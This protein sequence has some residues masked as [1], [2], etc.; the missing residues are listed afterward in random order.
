MCTFVYSIASGTVIGYCHTAFYTL[1]AALCSY[2]LCTCDLTLVQIDGR[3]AFTLAFILVQTRRL[4]LFR[5]A[6][7]VINLVKR[8]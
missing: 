2:L 7:S 4:I 8:D 6:K 5:R 1:A 3:I